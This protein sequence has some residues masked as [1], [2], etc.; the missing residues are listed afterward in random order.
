MVG[1]LELH[2]TPHFVPEGILSSKSM[3]DNFSNHIEQES[4]NCDGILNEMQ[5]L[6]FFSSSIIQFCLFQLT[7]YYQKSSDKTASRIRIFN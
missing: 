2:P 4:K 6:N 7:N 5:N 3:L 1:E